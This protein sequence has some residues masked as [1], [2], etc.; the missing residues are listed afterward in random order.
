[1]DSKPLKS[2]KP[3]YIMNSDDFP[4][5]IS[6]TGS[7]NE[8]IIEYFSADRVNH[9]RRRKFAGHLRVKALQFDGGI[10]AG[11]ATVVI[12]VYQVENLIA[13]KLEKCREL[14]R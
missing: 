4:N 12:S 1:M 6:P 14:P 3:R 11:F 8:A 2:T 7:V 13:E 10:L 9:I 5:R